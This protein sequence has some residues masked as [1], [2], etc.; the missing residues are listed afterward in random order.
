MPGEDGYELMGKVRARGP[1]RGGFIPAIALTAYAPAED[2]R[3]ALTVGYQMRIP[4]PVEP[5]LL[6]AAVASLTRG[7]S[8]NRA[9]PQQLK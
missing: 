1:E 2:A 6:A 9:R 5:S 8:K 4:K 7:V 3:R